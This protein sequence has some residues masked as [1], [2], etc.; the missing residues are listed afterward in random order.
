MAPSLVIGSNGPYAVPALANYLLIVPPPNSLAVLTL[1][2]ATSGDVGLPI[3]ATRPSLI[4]LDP[5][6]T[7]IYLFASVAIPSLLEI[8]FF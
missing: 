1:K 3:S 7:A 2:G 5:S 4:A 8:S 6:A